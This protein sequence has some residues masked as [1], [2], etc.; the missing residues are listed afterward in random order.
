MILRWVP[1]V[2]VAALVCCGPG[3]DKRECAGPHA[4]FN[5]T[6]RLSNR[7]LPVDTVVRVTYGGSGT[8]TYTLA[9][10]GANHEVI[11]CSLADSS[12]TPLDASSMASAGAAAEDEGPTFGLSCALWTGGFTKL[13]VHGSGFDPVSLDLL[14]VHTGCT[15]TKAVVLDSPDGG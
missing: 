12:G 4:D 10:P 15:V 6:L 13:E 9:A 11:F 5:V 8:E 7:P 1:L 3:N 2:L 14:P